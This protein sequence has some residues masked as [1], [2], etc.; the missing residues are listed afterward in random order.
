MTLLNVLSHSQHTLTK[1][2]FTTILYKYK[3][4]KKPKKNQHIGH[5]LLFAETECYYWAHMKNMVLVM[6]F[7]KIPK[8]S[9]EFTAFLC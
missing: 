4:L 2:T 3:Y 1:L 5:S 8:V 6:G 7:F 9:T